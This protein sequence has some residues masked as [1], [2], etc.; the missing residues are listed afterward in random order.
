MWNV[1]SGQILVLAL[2]KFSRS[3]SRNQLL[4]AYPVSKTF[5]ESSLFWMYFVVFATHLDWGRTSNGLERD[6][7]K[8]SIP[9]RG[10]DGAWS[11]WVLGH[12]SAGRS[13]KT[14]FIARSKDQVSVSVSELDSLFVWGRFGWN[15]SILIGWVLTGLKL[16]SSGCMGT[17]NWTTWGDFL[18]LLYLPMSIWDWEVLEEEEGIIHRLLLFLCECLDLFDFFFHLEEFKESDLEVEEE[19]EDDWCLLLFFDLW[20]LLDCSFHEG[21]VWE[22]SVELGGS[23]I[24][25]GSDIWEKSGSSGI[26]CLEEVAGFGNSDISECSYPGVCTFGSLWILPWDTWLLIEGA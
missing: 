15:S 25:L 19:E 13:L 22:T 8:C 18:A 12:N 14:S 26:N 1:V 24:T 20:S 9:E 17:G 11:C 5:I 3:K 2:V 10:L 23:I 16:G 21:L 6:S 4:Q 7:I